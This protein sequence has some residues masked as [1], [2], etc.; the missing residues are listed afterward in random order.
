MG[1]KEAVFLA[2]IAAAISLAFFTSLWSAR[3]SSL[4]GQNREAARA[5]A[6]AFTHVTVIDGKGAE[7]KTDFTVVIAGDRIIELGPSQRVRVPR[8]AQVINANGKFLI[9]GLWDMH[10]HLGEGGAALFPAL[11]ANGVTSVREMGGS[12]EL[13]L[14]LREK[15]K[16]GSLLG[17]RIKAAGLIL[18]SPRFIQMVERI[19]GESLTGKR[20]GVANAAD[21]RSAIEANVK[22]GA[23]FLKIR[24][25]AS[26][27]SYLA[28]TA[29]AK[30]AGLP[31]AGHLPD[32]ISPLEASDAG[33]RSLEHGWVLLD[34]I[35]ADKLKEIAAR[36]IK[37][38]THV[39]TTLTAGRG[40]RL[41]PDAEVL[42]IVDDRAGL[43]D[44]RRKYIPQALANYWRKQIEMKKFETPL[45]WQTV[46]ENNRHIFRTLHQAGVKIMAGTDLAAPLCYPGFGLHDELELLVSRIGLTPAEALQSATRIPATFMGMGASLGTVEKGK[47]A[48]LVLLE[49]NPLSDIMHTRK[50]AAVVI[51][52]RLFS[53]AELQT[54]LEKTAVEGGQR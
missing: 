13:A 8:D 47:L 7:A 24:T 2:R 52:G 45:D 14:T 33:Q 26:R 44:A 31:L 30:R 35:P 19:N 15:V 38:D 16:A 4:S 6:V 1:K 37:N 11:L 10:V 34:T 50:I 46:A 21:A 51:G 17:P 22:M 36:L 27:E 3:V 41:T 49:A 25:C 32:G 43:R 39:T 20:I 54:L 28:I 18:E 12:G 29:E 9:P 48:D 42:A 23:D 53:K 40:F 5:G